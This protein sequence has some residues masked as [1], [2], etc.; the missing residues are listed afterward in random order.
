MENRRIQMTGR[1]NTVKILGR[2]IKLGISKTDRVLVIGW[3]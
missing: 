2:L 3:N 1:E